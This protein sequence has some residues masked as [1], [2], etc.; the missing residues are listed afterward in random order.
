[1]K[2]VFLTLIFVGISFSIYLINYLGA[3]QP[4]EIVRESR[5]ILQLVW[6][7][8]RGAYHQI[9]PTI[10]K[11]EE[12]ARTN[13]IPC[14]NTFG[15]YIDDPETVDQDRLR[16][17][18]GCVVTVGEPLP[19][20]IQQLAPPFRFE[21]RPGADYVV[22]KFSG[23]PAIGPFKVY[24]KI[25]KYLEDNALKPSG[26]PLEVYRVNGNDVTTEY[27]FPIQTVK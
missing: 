24:P 3:G 19:V 21:Q 17:H 1:M 7:E 5:G 4:V 8:H 13:N 2:W 26:P 16:S 25:R 18:G 12:W 27:L 22:G 11:V 20:P 15:E 14:P 23:S 9:M 10:T 6:I